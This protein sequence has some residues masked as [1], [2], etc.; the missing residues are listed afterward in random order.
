MRSSD[1]GVSRHN[2]PRTDVAT[3]AQM[4]TAPDP[5]IVLDDHRFYPEPLSSH[6]SPRR[7]SVVLISN[8][9]VLADG[10]V[11]SDGNS[12][13]RYEVTACIQARPVS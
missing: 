5:D 13:I 11:G 2:G 7:E 12:Q 8:A 6:T 3:G 9:H 4:N 1:Y 10:N